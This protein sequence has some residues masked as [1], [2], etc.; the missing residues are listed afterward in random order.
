MATAKFKDLAVLT[1]MT[2]SIIVPTSDGTTTK[3]ITGANLKTYF[4]NGNSATVTNGVYTSGSYADPNWITSLS[5]TK[6]VTPA[7]VIRAQ[8]SAGGNAEDGGRWTFTTV[9]GDASAVFVGN[10]TTIGLQS[11]AYIVI[12]LTGFT[13]YPSVKNW[14]EMTP[15]AD[16]GLADSPGTNFQSLEITPA[17]GLTGGVLSPGNPNILTT[18]TPNTHKIYLVANTTSTQDWY[19]E[20]RQ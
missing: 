11:N 14:L 9:S 19:F 12:T 10:G 3:Q 18:F 13:K 20:F 15:V 8:R 1:S 7:T 6:V 4:L 5:Y 16:G 2:D 17:S